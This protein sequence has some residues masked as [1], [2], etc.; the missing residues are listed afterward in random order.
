MSGGRRISY[1]SLT[2]GGALLA[3]KLRERFGGVA[4]LPRCQSLGCRHC[5]PFDSISEALPRSFDAGETAVCVMAAGVVFRVLAPHLKSKQEDPAV[6][7]VDEAG[8]HVVPLLGGHAAGANGLARE[9][10]G[11]L[12]AEAALTT[13]SDV[14]GKV[15][16]DE[17][18]RRLGA[19]V[20]NP[21]ELRKVTALLVDSRPVCIESAQNPEIPGYGWLAPG[22]DPGGYAA[23][24]LITHAADGE[25]SQAAGGV[26]AGSG[27]K[28]PAQIPTARLICRSVAAG[29]GCRRGTAANRII[30]A[31]S[32]VCEE[33]GVDR[34]AIGMLASIKA[35][36]D[37]AG[38]AAAA[39]QLDAGLVFYSPAEL[40]AM[41]RPGSAFVEE[42][43]GAAAVCEP[44]ALIAAGSGGT[45]LAAKTKAG[46]V[47]VA[48][49]ASL[50]QFPPGEKAGRGQIFVVGTGAGTGATLTEEAR[51]AI[52]AADVVVGYHTYVDQLRRIFP[53]KEYI[54]GPMGAELDRCRRAL[55]QA[56]EGLTVALVSSGDAGVYGMA[57]PLLEMA[58]SE[59]PVSVFVIPGVTAA[60]IAA[61]RLGA[62]LMNDY[63][64]LSLSDL[65]TPW[66]EVIRRVRLAA[67]SDMVICLYNPASKKR[68]ALLAEV[69]AIFLKVRPPGTPV[70]W[71]R[72]AGGPGES[73]HTGV[74]GDLPRAAI[75]MRTIIIVGNSQTEL[76]RGMLITKRGYEKKGV[77][78]EPAPD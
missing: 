48:L 52:Q 63:I 2:A 26:K 40:K 29:V 8:R 75:D 35:K 32:A 4:H 73:V 16:P 6:I 43:V 20:D 25:E 34:R 69:C 67:A 42:K 47:T 78:Q 5:D 33:N 68:R 12:G 44:A 60:Q 55:E 53:G 36:Q 62:P 71:V 15:A 49:A 9:I 45:L 59:D 30:D 74:L 22:G 76:R 1:F 23:R 77:D 11:F 31:I 10:A 17:V 58:G 19:V 54:S 13:A 37:E 61:A 7:I 72:D 38:L 51:R 57:G 70:G 66:R 21:V 39:A 64:T 3:L 50:G 14:Q 24:L 28:R 41:N 56:L 65:L 46:P 18:A 27:R